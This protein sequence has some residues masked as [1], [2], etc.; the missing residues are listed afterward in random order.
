MDQGGGGV[1]ELRPGAVGA[2]ATEAHCGGVAEGALA[3][4]AG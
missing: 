1:G 2:G 4:S 3:V